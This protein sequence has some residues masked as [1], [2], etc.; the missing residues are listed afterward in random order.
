MLQEQ[1]A[2]D[3]E[4]INPDELQQAFVMFNKASCNLAEVYQ[5]LEKQVETL[6]S[7]LAAVRGEQQQQH[8]QKQRIAGRLQNIL[9]VLPAGVIVL[10]EDGIIQQHNPAAAELLD[11]PLLGQTWRSIVERV[12][13]PR[14]DDGHD[15]TLLDNRCVN[16]STQSLE[17][18]GGQIILLKEVTE[19]RNLQQQLDRLKRLSAMGDIASSLAHQVRTPLSTALLYASHLRN[20]DIGADSQTRFVNKL[21]SRLRHMETIVE[22]MLLFARGGSFDLKP[23]LLTELLKDFLDSVESQLEQTATRLVVT[24]QAESAIVNVNKHALVSSL[25]NLLNNAIQASEHDLVVNISLAQ[26]GEQ[27]L[28]INFADNGPGIDESVRDKIFEPF[29]TTRSEGTGL[30]L[31]VAEAVIRSHGGKIKLSAPSGKGTCFQITLPLYK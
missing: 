4:E 20:T 3:T 22:D 19:T 9:K 31:A 12:F 13:R 8:Q 11:V 21:I 17:G 24:N 18:E 7:E 1:L 23:V 15:I 2:S 28:E 6:S 25:Q 27:K 10:D 29:Y 5:S 26:V 16:I 14:W 30:G